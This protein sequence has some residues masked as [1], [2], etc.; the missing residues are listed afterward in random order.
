MEITDTMPI[1]ASAFFG[2]VLE[3]VFP[4]IISLYTAISSGAFCIQI[5][6]A[7]AT[8]GPAAA[9]EVPIANDSGMVSNLIQVIS[10]HL[11]PSFLKLDLQL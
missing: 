10:Q 6:M 7:S 3:A 11:R 8:K 9:I 4:A 1:A 5:I 2:F